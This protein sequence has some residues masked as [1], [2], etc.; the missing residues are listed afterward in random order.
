MI[1]IFLSAHLFSCS[2]ILDEKSNESITTVTGIKDLEAILRNTM[3]VNELGLSLADLGADDYLLSN[4]AFAN[5]GINYQN[6]YKWD[7]ETQLN[8]WGPAYTAVYSANFVLQEMD[9]II[10][11]SVQ[12]R[13]LLRGQALF[14][15]ALT[16][17]QLS[18]IYCKPYTETAGADP[19]LPLRMTPNIEE[20]ITRSTLAATYDRIFTDLNEAITLLDPKSPT[21]NVPSK[22]A[23]FGLLAR[24]YLSMRMYTEAENNAQK[25]LDITSVLVDYNNL[26]TL[27]NPSIPGDNMERIF[28]GAYTMAVPVPPTMNPSLVSLYQPEDLRRKVFYTFNADGSVLFKGS[29]SK[30][31]PVFPFC[32]IATDE[33]YLIRAEC[34]ARR[35]SLNEAASD[36]KTLLDKRYKTGTSPSVSFGGQEQAIAAVLLERKKELVFRSTRWSDIRR[37]NLDGAGITLSRTINGTEFKL[38]PNDK[39][40]VWLIPVEVINLSGIAQNER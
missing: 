18:Q 27:A 2:K 16:F 22:A 21:P 23:C 29:Y 37:F 11:G 36:I 15:R 17:F 34:R 32:G 7:G 4:S 19:G 12:Q 1:T 26:D 14:I 38:P 39:R 24:I 5:M 3:L 30:Q 31:S 10:D 9:R 33:V 35:N 13:Q 20:K 40:W 28:D 6:G 8:G 25:Y